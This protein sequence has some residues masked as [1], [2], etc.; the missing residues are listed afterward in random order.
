V[1]LYESEI[2]SLTLREQ[3]RLRVFVDGMLRIFRPERDEVI[4]DWKMMCIEELDSSSFSLNVIRMTKSMMMI[5]AGHFD[6]MGRF[7]SV[8]LPTRGM[9]PPV[10]YSG[11]TLQ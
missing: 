7:V 1:A 2:W 10:T 4:A 6:Y 11:W 5:W 3:D 8:R 9:S